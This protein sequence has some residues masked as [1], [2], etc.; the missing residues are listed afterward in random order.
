MSSS[1]A[2][3]AS[4]PSTK[5][6][7]KSAKSSDKTS[8][9]SVTKETTTTTTTDSSA[10]NV[11]E[12]VHKKANEET[13]VR[14]NKNKDLMISYQW[15]HQKLVL[16]IRDYLVEKGNLDI[17]MDVDEMS[18][19]MNERMAEGVYNSKLFIMCMSEK[20]ADSRNCKKEYNYADR[21]G[22]EIIPV[23]VQS[24]FQPQLGTG[25]DII[26]GSSI[27][28]DV[29]KSFEEEM[30]KLLNDIQKCLKDM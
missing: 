1:P 5:S 2:N 7:T 27:Y 20:Y 25:L 6:S 10:K 22:K 8:S 4:Q 19:C 14:R 18:G 15:D 3:K 29:A 16:K 28:Y 13:I 21:L 26:L 30:K 23:K 24:N 17:W 11:A 12:N 9:S